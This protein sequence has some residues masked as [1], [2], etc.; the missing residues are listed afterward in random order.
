M[1]QKIYITDPDKIESVKC[2]CECQE[3]SINWIRGDK[4]ATVC[5]SDNTT[6]TRLIKAMRND[7][8]N[9]KCYYYKSSV[10][11]DSGKLMN[12]FFEFPNKLLSFRAH[13][14]REYT[15]E[16][17]AEMGNRMRAWRNSADFAVGE[18]ED[19]LDS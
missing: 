18:D 2:D 1:E 13:I 3:T 19:E 12:Y 6:L 8:E 4:L 16:Q 17:K 10:D 7:P 9:Y 14:H 5:V 15:D 11:R